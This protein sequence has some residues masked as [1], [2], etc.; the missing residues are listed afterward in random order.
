MLLLAGSLTVMAGATIAPSLPAIRDHFTASGTGNVEYLTRFVLTAPALFI[1]LFGTLAGV[2]ADRVGRRPLMLGSIALFAIA[3]SAGAL[4]DSMGALI[5]SRCLLGVAVAG[6]MTATT[7]LVGDYF[8]GAARRRY[9]GLQSA[10]IGLSGVL[11]LTMGG[12]LAELHWRAPF[13]V[14]LLAAAL[15]PGVWLWLIEP[16]RRTQAEAASQ[17]TSEVPNR[18]LIALVYVTALLGSSLFYLVPTQLP[19]HLAD[20]GLDAPSSTG[21]AM[22]AITLFSAAAA[23]FYARTLTRMGILS[24]FA[25]AFGSLAVGFMLIALAQSAGLLLVGTVFTGIGMGMMMP[26]LS[27][28]LLAVAPPCLR[29][30]L[31]GGLT[32]SIFVGQ[33]LSPLVSQ[34]LSQS[35]GLSG[36]FAAA[37]GLLTL[38]A[39]I[40]GAVVVGNALRSPAPPQPTPAPAAHPGSQARTV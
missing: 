23:M 37:A 10:W 12:L 3:G 22:A 38:M 11:F 24:V 8:D 2:I 14:Y 32:T 20:I 39:L 34:P 19:F 35:V 21:L 28:S 26:S 18:P 1:A 33:F 15:L 9:M 25:L 30:R 27:V 7:T 17:S 4:L 16:R 31:A 36:T 6:T 5:A 29:G 40:P 13:L